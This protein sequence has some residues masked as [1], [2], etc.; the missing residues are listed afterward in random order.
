MAHYKSDLVDIN[1]NTG[2][3]HRSFLSHAIG[4]KDD[5]ADRFGIRAYRD[6]V[7]VDL[8]GASCHAWFTNS[9]G[10]TI[11]LTSYGTVSG[12]VAYV[13]LPPACYDY[14]GQFTLAIKIVGGGVSSTVRIVDG[15][16]DNINVGGAV[17]VPDSVPDYS[18]I[19]AQYDAM[20]AATSAANTAIADAFD[21]TKD[22][23]AGKY[24]VNDGAL[25]L[26][27]EGH[28]ANVTWANTTK[29]AVNFGDEETDLKN[30]TSADMFAERY[31][32]YNSLAPF[33]MAA[34]SERAAFTRY[35]NRFTIN[36]TFGSDDNYFLKL[37]EEGSTN[38]SKS[39]NT[40]MGWP[41]S[42]DFVSGHT[43][44]VKLVLL[45]GTV[46]GTNR[47]V[48][49]K[50]DSTFQIVSTTDEAIIKPGA[51]S[52][53]IV[54]NAGANASFSNA[55]YTFTIEDIT[56]SELK[57]SSKT[58]V[59]AINE[60]DLNC[61][62]ADYSLATVIPVD[63]DLNDYT[64][65]G[66]YRVGSVATAQT[67]SNL[68]LEGVPGRLFVM[69]PYNNNRI[70][71]I[72]VAANKKTIFVRRYTVK[73]SE[74][75]SL[76]L[77]GS[78]NTGSA[79]STK[80]LAY[81]W[82]VNNRAVDSYGNLFFGYISENG[83]CGVGCRYPDGMITKTDLFASEDCDDH[84]AP[85]V[86][87]LPIDG[88]EY[89]CAIG[90]TGH[91]TDSKI[92]VYVAE[93][94]NTIN[95]D[96]TN[97][98]HTITSPSGYTIQCSY[99][100]AY[101]DTEEAKIYNFFRIKQKDNVQNTYRMIWMCAISADYGE[102][103][104][105]YRVFTISSNETLFYM[106]SCDTTSN[107]WLKRIVLQPNTTNTDIKPIRAGFVNPKTLNILDANGDSINKPMTLME[108]G[109]LA[110]DPNVTIADYDDFTQIIPTDENHRFRILDVWPGQALSF[111]YAK[112]VE[113]VSDHHN[114][115]DWILYCYKNGE[116]IEIAHLGLP[117]FVGSCYVT[118]ANFIAD[119]NHI[120]YSKNDSASK[121]GKHS[122]HYVTMDGS[123][124]ESDEII[125][126]AG[127]TIARPMRYDDGS[128][129]YLKGK[130][131]EGSGTRYLT[132]HFGIGFIDSF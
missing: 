38:Y 69:H 35:G 36:G 13:T 25:Y 1:L 113:N 72:W 24:V 107:T 94:P 108:D 99:S 5:D 129:M 59:G 76:L 7:P 46:S 49:Y 20:V 43:Y 116:R 48:M 97:R 120:V 9:Q 33:S 93:E 45:S 90:S 77:S 123:T 34:T 126:W 70:V 96:F 57:T 10:T 28:T 56:E 127:D 30:A 40:A 66:N 86:I 98:T 106:Y 23:P 12:N 74:W 22:Y 124:I 88:K 39:A 61:L 115:T 37:S 130:Y 122:L 79:Q 118:G 27:P 26:L 32:K 128:L 95:C 65:D 75:E 47:V 64:T 105:I 110:Y 114:I 81:S 111:L 21:A 84:N 80:G 125:K 82:W 89:V 78:I 109:D 60:L 54:F 11:A 121:D 4:Q 102:T 68:P 100:Q 51:V 91:N 15:V 83:N 92:N 87:I 119:T 3:I 44:R 52:A 85:S 131:R 14:D 103:W 19:I 67:V 16:V 31:I 62:T 55:V 29:T 73:W 101:Y 17:V 71:Q 41:K 112:S 50:S 42:V 63:S 6:G 132:W 53:N 2:N 58:I 104:A 18:T 8:S 117:Y